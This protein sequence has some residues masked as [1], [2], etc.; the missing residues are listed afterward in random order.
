MRIAL[1]KALALFIE[2][3]DRL[4]CLKRLPNADG[5]RFQ[6]I[7]APAGRDAAAVGRQARLRARVV[8]RDAV[9]DDHLRG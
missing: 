6:I 3:D 2:R 4:I 5:S 1:A 9:V 8:E 7:T